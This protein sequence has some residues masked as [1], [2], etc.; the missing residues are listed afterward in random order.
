MLTPPPDLD[1]AALVAALARAWGLAPVTLE[2]RPVGWGSHHWAVADG[3][4]WRWF[5][6]VDDLASKRHTRDEPLDAAADRLSAALATA[7]ALHERG[8]AFVVGPVSTL[9]GAPTVRISERY[10][11]AL[12]PYLDGERFGWGP[13]PTEEHRDAVVAMVVALHKGPA[14]AGA[15]VDDFVIPHRDELEAALAG[16]PSTVEGPY[17]AKLAALVAA[18]EP[19]IRSVLARYDELVGAADPGRAVLTHGE[20]HP[21]NTMRVGGDWRLIDWETVRV[22][23][24]ERD[25]WGLIHS[26]PDVRDGYELA[27]GVAPDPAM[28]EL[29]RLRWDLADLAV[30]AS[31]FRRPHEG[32]PEDDQ[33]WTILSG[34]ITSLT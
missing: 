3:A 20:P 31:R 17:T 21:G 22:A 16:T 28:L 14:P 33:A 25:L 27:T 29:F 24:P 1:S 18:H 26:S 12:T 23:Q 10:V 11:A 15:P 30:D 8:H 13:F 32:S 4:G 34:V 19:A 7:A 9:D 5:L 6:T 2:Y